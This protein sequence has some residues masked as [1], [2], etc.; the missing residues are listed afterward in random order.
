MAEG[1]SDEDHIPAV[2][3]RRERV[4]NRTEYLD[5]PPFPLPKLKPPHLKRGVDV[6]LHKAGVNNR[7]PA[8]VTAAAA[9]VAPPATRGHIARRAQVGPGPAP[10]VGLDRITAPTIAPSIAPTIAQRHC[11]LVK[12]ENEIGRHLVHALC[13]SRGRG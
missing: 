2:F 3:S 8:V 4:D 5:P 12:D 11:F 1:V 6:V 7:D 10:A 13:V 9:A